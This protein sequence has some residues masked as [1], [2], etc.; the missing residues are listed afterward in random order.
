MAQWLR[1]VRGQTPKLGEFDVLTVE[2]EDGSE[3]L[4]ASN[5][6]IHALNDQPATVED[7]GFDTEAILRD[8]WKRARKEN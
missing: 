7:D 6:R 3:R 1:H 2:M 5:L 8:A 4:F